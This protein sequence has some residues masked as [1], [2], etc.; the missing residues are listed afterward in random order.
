MRC[1]QK[2]V[3]SF[4]HQANMKTRIEHDSIGDIEVSSD[5]YWGP[6]TERS[7][8]NFII[9]NHLMPLLVIKKLALIKKASAITNHSFGKLSDDKMQLISRVCDEICSGQLDSQFPLSVWQ[10]GSGTQ[11][12]MNV[13]EVISIR[14][15]E[16]YSGNRNDKPRLLHPNDDVNMSQ[17]SN[18][19]FPSAMHMA[20]YDMINMVSIPGLQ[21]LISSLKG[22]A[23]R[24]NNTVKIGRTH[25]MDATPITVGQEFSAY[26]D[27]LEQGKSRLK[28]SA[29]RLLE[30]PLGGTAVGTGLNTPSGYDSAVVKNLSSISG[31]SY[32]P[33][34]NKYSILSAHDA[35]VEVHAALKQISISL[36]KI[37]NDIRLM[38][39]GPRCGL[40]ELT[41]PA[42]EPGSSIMPGKVNPTQIEA[43]CMVCAKIAGND[44]TIGLAAMQGQFELNTYKPLIITTFLESACLLGDACV[45]FSQKCISGTKVNHDTLKQNLDKALMLN[46]V[47]SREIG[48]EKAA[49]IA[50]I[51]ANKNIGLREAAIA[52]GFVTGEEY[53][54]WIDV[55]KMV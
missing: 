21:H 40:N 14:G 53:D 44:L 9:G 35:M 19:V 11:T 33:S 2:C 49:V 4:F 28:Q 12:N 15:Q 26:I 34:A 52:S 3:L 51:A 8:L 54:T 45:S 41:I 32:R 43:L 47:L 37:A 18:D 42:N 20:A 48:Y 39:S 46:T 30:L 36:N 38:A 24:Y 31:V 27:M 23:R 13:N 1:E 7:R 10:T 22:F 25:L 5:S 16:M 29:R 55:N 6:Q 50:K 17:S